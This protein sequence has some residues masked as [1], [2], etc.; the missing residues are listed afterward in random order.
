MYKRLIKRIL[1]DLSNVASY[2]NC[3]LN[4]LIRINDDLFGCIDCVFRDMLKEEV[5]LS[6]VKQGVRGLI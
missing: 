6:E 3:R 2:N 5:C 4:R 1:K